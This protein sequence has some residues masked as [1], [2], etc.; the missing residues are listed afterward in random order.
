MV[1]A[2][3]EQ[4]A[5]RGGRC[6]HADFTHGVGLQKLVARAGFNNVNVAFLAGE[7]EL[8]ISGDGRSG[9]GSPGSDSLAVAVI[10]Q[11][12]AYFLRSIVHSQKGSP[13]CMFLVRL[14]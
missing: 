1:L 12:S 9:E 5:L 14:K 4:T 10:S 3:D 2:A 11:K 13:R 8:I 6:R 7:V